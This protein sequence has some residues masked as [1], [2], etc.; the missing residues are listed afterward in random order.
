MSDTEKS[1]DTPVSEA[2]APASALQEQPREKEFREGGY[3]WVV[4][5]VAALLNGHTWGL[6]SSYAVFLAYYLRTGTIEGASPLGFAFVGGLSVG[7]ALLISPFATSLAG[8]KYF[9]TRRTIWLGTVFE[10][11]SFVGASFTSK[12]WHLILSQG[13]CFG[14]GMGLIFVASVPVPSQWFIKKRSLANGCAAAGSG[15]GG[16]AYS[17]G[18]NAMISSVGLEWTFRVL[19]IICFVVNCTCGAL[20]R[21]RNHAIGSI[22]TALNWALLKRP[23][24]LMYLGWMSF[25][26]IPYTALI[27][28]IV[29]Y[30]QSVGLPAAQASLVGALLNLSQGLGRPIIGVSSDKIGRLNVASFCTAFVCIMTLT[31]WIFSF[32]L[33]TCILFALLAGWA[34]GVIWATAAP[35]C[36]EVV[37]IQ[38]LP[39]ALSL[40][41]VMMVLPSTFAEVI[42]LE[43]RKRKYRY[44][45][46]F[47]GL[48]YLAAFCFIWG[49]RTWKVSEMENAHLDKEQRER[50]IQDGGVVR[51]EEAM[52]R[53]DS[54]VQRAS[55]ASRAKE[56][57]SMTK[58]LWAWQKV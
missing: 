10:T 9:G 48:M 34:S 5:T 11:I 1:G 50:A 51:D 29:D 33:A 15:F 2:N 44:A 24:Y 31:L 58:Y 14:V 12:L 55:I 53:Q 32:T 54:I 56:T 16:L 49:L 46:L 13:I 28:S 36:A 7:I 40:T 30:S 26:M 23:S 39:S 8:H 35:V 21:D 41:W 57:V 22:H 45:Q 3:G 47:I 37:G 27:F 52:R 4:V 43:I 18:T 38:I 20:I 25:S 17:L 42:V 19:A 6:N